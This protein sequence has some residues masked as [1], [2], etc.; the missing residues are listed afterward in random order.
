MLIKIRE[1][2]M[3][4]EEGIAYIKPLLQT[5]QLMCLRNRNTPGQD[6]TTKRK[7]GSKSMEELSVGW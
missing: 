7:S 3:T 2:K 5:M 4:Q 6:M 1:G